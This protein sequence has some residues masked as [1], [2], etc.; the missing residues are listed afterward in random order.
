MTVID[1]TRRRLRERQLAGDGRA[2][3]WARAEARRRQW[4][5]LKRIRPFIATTLLVV[6]G[7]V[8]LA[9]LLIPDTFVRGLVVGGLIVG[10]IAAMAT[11]VMQATGTA[12][13]EMGA[14]A[15]QWTASEL[16]PLRRDGWKVV[17]HLALR[18][19][20]IDHVVIGG[21]GV[22]AVETK[23]SAHGWSVDQP[24]H[25]LRE[26]LRQVRGNA[27]DLRMWEDFK[28]NGVAFVQPVLFLWGTAGGAITTPSTPTTIDGVIVIYG[29]EAA[30]HWRHGVST[31]KI[32]SDTRAPQ[33]DALAIDALWAALDTRTKRVDQLEL[34]RNP[35]LPSLFR[36][37][38][39]GLG[40]FT[41]GSVALFFTLEAG[42]WVHAWWQWGVTVVLAALTARVL[43]RRVQRLRPYVGG[44]L[45]GLLVSVALVVVRQIAFL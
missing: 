19:W 38:W 24:D 4:T 32:P 7:F 5:F 39:T 16:R 1:E 22:F 29:K 40:I 30:K 6:A 10:S 23:W 36:L 2:G 21:S 37:Y 18:P 28:S 3:S 34:E 11:L 14:T 13:T 15:E 9:V 44:W 42:I 26:A 35:Q 27:K 12:N 33:L 43:A 45:L 8:A 41:A 31:G 25:Y 17:N 20:D